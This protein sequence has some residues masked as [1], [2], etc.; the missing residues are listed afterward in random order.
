M[1]SQHGQH[2]GDEVSQIVLKWYPHSQ[3][4]FCRAGRFS[5]YWLIM[6]FSMPYKRYQ[7]VKPI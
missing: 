5:A 4:S 7:A 3:A 2:S 1:I 6:V